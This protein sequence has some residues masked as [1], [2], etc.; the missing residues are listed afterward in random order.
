MS[1]VGGGNADVG[2]VVGDEGRGQ[3]GE[4]SKL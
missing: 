1:E 2:S 4:G 3:Y